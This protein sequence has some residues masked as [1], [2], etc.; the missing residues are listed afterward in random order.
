[1]LTGCF[2]SRE[3]LESEWLEY[4]RRYMNVYEPFMLTYPQPL[5]LAPTS[6]IDSFADDAWPILTHGSQVLRSSDDNISDDLGRHIDS[7]TVDLAAT[8]L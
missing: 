1:M 5:C 3:M 4:Q 2:R 8:A 7:V 6:P